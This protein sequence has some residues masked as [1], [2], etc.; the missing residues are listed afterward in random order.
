MHKKS[1]VCVPRL[2]K[3]HARTVQLFCCVITRCCLLGLGDLRNTEQELLLLY[4]VHATGLC[5]VFVLLNYFSDTGSVLLCVYMCVCVRV[6]VCIRLCVYVCVFHIL[7][8][9][10]TYFLLC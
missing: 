6:C 3:T 4:S 1:R 7:A 2:H 8:Y 10:F 9:L 5:Y